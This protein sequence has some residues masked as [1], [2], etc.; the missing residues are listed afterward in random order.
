M[1][2]LTSCVSS[3]NNRPLRNAVCWP[4][5]ESRSDGQEQ[6]PV[7]FAA[8]ARRNAKFHRGDRGG[9]GGDSKKPAAAA[10][11]RV[12]DEAKSPVHPKGNHTWADCFQNVAN[13]DKKKPA[14][15]TKGKGKPKSAAVVDANAMQCDDDS[16]VSAVSLELSEELSDGAINDPSDQDSTDI[17]GLCAQLNEHAE[18]LST[19]GHGHCRYHPRTAAATPGKLLGKEAAAAAAAAATVYSRPPT[20]PP[21]CR[22]IPCPPPSTVPSTVPPTVPTTSSSTASATAPSLLR[23]CLHNVEACCRML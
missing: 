3:L 13:K 18:D 21:P 10:A 20:R 14:Y 5:L 6:H 15:P 4:M 11:T 19:R 2:M 17:H 8:G 23:H 9:K 1:T 7:R 16:A 12:S 22:R